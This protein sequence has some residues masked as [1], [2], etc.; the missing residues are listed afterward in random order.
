MPYGA[1][2]RAP[3]GNLA[4][5]TFVPFESR[6]IPHEADMKNRLFFGENLAVLLIEVYRVLSRQGACT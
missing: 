3:A 5:Y 1:L 6:F 4:S 2:P